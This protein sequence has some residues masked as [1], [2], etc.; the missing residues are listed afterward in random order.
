LNLIKCRS[1]GI[2]SGFLFKAP[3]N[4]LLVFDVD[5]ADFASFGELAS[6]FLVVA[7]FGK[8]GFGEG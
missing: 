3:K 4:V 5:N 8:A 7:N 1:L 2:S 6:E